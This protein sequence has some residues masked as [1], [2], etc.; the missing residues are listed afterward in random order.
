MA[1]EFY[2]LRHANDFLSIATETPIELEGKLWPSVEHFVTAQMFADP[3]FQEKIRNTR[4]SQL[5]RLS[6]RIKGQFPRADWPQM[7]DEVMYRANAA[8]FAQ[9]PTLRA[10]LMATEDEELV[11]KT[12]YH[13]H[14]GDGGDGSGQNMLG[15]ILMRIRRELRSSAQ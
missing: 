11:L 15:K 7:R 6:T 8:K 1:I 14:F 12:I 13:K 10:R 3:W 2:R 5:L 9:H 4:A